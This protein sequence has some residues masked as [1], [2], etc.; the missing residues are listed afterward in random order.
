M[1]RGKGLSQEQVL[2]MTYQLA[3]ALE[4]GLGLIPSLLVLVESTDEATAAALTRLIRQMERGE[5]FS[6]AL[7]EQPESF[8]SSYRRVVE[9]AQET[10]SLTFTMGRLAKTLEQQSMTR[11][12]LI[13]ALIY[14]VTLL[15]AALCMMFAMLY[16]V[17]PMILTVTREAGVEPPLL[18]RFLMALGDRRLLLGGV[19]TVTVSVL[20]GRTAWSHPRLG[21]KL[22]R[23]FESETPPGR[24]LNRYRLAATTRQMALMLEGGV[25]ILRAILYSGRVGEDSLNLRLAFQNLYERVK[26][27]ESLTHAMERDPFFPKLLTAMVSVAEEVGDLPRMLYSYS[28]LCEDSVRD[29]IDTATHLIEPLLLAGMGFGVGLILVGGFLPIYQLANL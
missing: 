23:F 7:A 18:T 22:H 14:P 20:I 27:G 1:S 4:G 2:R 13:G 28:A 3:T 6:A 9:T 26:E 15:L 11:R 29:Q 10:G 24:F 19:G 12:R 25:D 16:F 17:L 5:S 8:T 21:P